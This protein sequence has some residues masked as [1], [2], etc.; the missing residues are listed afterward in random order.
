M[1]QNAKGV[2]IT[3]NVF[4][5]AWVIAIEGNKVQDITVKNNVIIGVQGKP[6]VPEGS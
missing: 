1:M 2:T 3:N 6:T 4:F 5:K